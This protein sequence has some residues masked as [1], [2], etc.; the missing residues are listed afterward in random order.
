MPQTKIDPEN[1]EETMEALA[2]AL[3]AEGF[4]ASSQ[5]TGGGILCVILDRVG[6]GEIAWGLADVNWGASVTD[7]DGEVISGIDT[8]CPGDTDD[9][10]KIV[11]ALRQPSIDNGAIYT[12]A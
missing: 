8:E 2:D 9:L 5:D 7:E 6:G 11:A 1:E 10:A 4:R 3:S 12:A